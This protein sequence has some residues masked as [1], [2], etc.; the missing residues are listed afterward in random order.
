MHMPA[1]YRLYYVMTWSLR[2]GKMADI[3][4][5]YQQGMG[6]WPRMPGVK[7]VRGFV[8]QFSLAQEDLRAE[9]WMELEDYG[10]MD[11][12]DRLDGPIRQE[13]LDLVEA[14]RGVVTPGPA[15]LM[16]DMSG[17]VP[18]EAGGEL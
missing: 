16:G 12:W 8:P 18:H 10:V 11:T 4:A 1:P 15:R 7:S 5:W 9:V 17:S 3:M 2:P 13:W 14:S 6:L